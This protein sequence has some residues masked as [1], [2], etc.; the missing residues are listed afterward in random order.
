MK[1]KKHEKTNL[2]TNLSNLFVRLWTPDLR[3]FDKKI[4]CLVKKSIC[5]QPRKRDR[6]LGGDVSPCLSFFPSLYLNVSNSLF[7]RCNF[8]LSQNKDQIR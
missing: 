1:N 3:I 5:I 4:G 6:R 2:K 7:Y 8:F